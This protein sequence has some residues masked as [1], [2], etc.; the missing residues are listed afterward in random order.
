MDLPESRIERLEDCDVRDT[1]IE[2]DPAEA[3]EAIIWHRDC[4]PVECERVMLA[5]KLIPVDPG[6]DHDLAR[7]I[8]IGP[9]LTGRAL[10]ERRERAKVVEL[11]NRKKRGV[12]SNGSI[13]DVAGAVWRSTS[14]EY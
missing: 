5:S 13:P 1:D 9:K 10:A 14:R 3:L 7:V 12:T 11:L 6:E 2:M 8:S 4:D